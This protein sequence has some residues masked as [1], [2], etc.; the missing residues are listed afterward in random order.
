VEELK[1]SR[2]HVLSSSSYLH[3]IYSYPLHKGTREG[4]WL[5]AMRLHC[6]RRMFIGRRFYSACRIALSRAFCRPNEQGFAVMPQI[7]CAPAATLRFKSTLL[8]ST[9]HHS[10]QIRRSTQEVHLSYYEITKYSPEVCGRLYIAIYPSIFLTQHKTFFSG[11][12]C[13]A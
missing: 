11:L 2:N 12:F 6:R 3:F 1:S 10:C 5:T 4:F 8:R 7:S 9:M 13:S